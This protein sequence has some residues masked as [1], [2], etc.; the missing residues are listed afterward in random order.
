[1]IPYHK[2]NVRSLIHSKGEVL[3]EEYLGEGTK[4]NCLL[5]AANYQRVLAM[6]K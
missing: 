2:G 3:G 5:D 4:V 1:M 6:L